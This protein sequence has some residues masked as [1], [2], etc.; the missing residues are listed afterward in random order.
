MKSIK[1]QL[2]DIG[3]YIILILFA[4][5]MIIFITLW[6]KWVCFLIKFIWNL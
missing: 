5:G 6:L 1:Q 3:W 4:T 2:K